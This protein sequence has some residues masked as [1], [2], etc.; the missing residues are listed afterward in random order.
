MGNESGAP[1]MRVET[2]I[3]KLENGGLG[4]SLSVTDAGESVSLT[5]GGSRLLVANTGL[6]DAFILIDEAGETP[7]L[8]GQWIPAKTSVLFHIPPDWEYDTAYGICASGETTRL[9]FY[10][11]DEGV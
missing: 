10:T 3:Y 11:G 7:S 9:I 1:L 8:N 6:F 2:L 4:T 5:G